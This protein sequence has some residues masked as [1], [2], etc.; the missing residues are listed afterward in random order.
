MARGCGV[1][2]D[3]GRLKAVNRSRSDGNRRMREGVSDTSVGVSLS[4]KLEL[5][6]KKQKRRRRR[7]FF[8]FTY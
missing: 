6:Q 2:K 8:L 5:M 3:G 1:N 4:A 7:D